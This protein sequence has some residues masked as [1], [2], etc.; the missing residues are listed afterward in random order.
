MVTI[1]VSNIF[2][3]GNVADADE[4]NDNFTDVFN[5]TIANARAI[6]AL[7]ITGNAYP[8]GGSE[9]CLPMDFTNS[10]YSDGV[11][12]AS[13]QPS[14]TTT[15]QWRGN[16]YRW[17]F[18]TY[19][20]NMEDASRDTNLWSVDAGTGTVTETGGYL[21]IVAVDAEPDQTKTLTLD[22]V[23]APDL[24]T[25]GICSIFFYGTIES[26]ISGATVAK[27]Q[28]IDE[29]AN[30]VDIKSYTSDVTNGWFEL[31]IDPGNDLADLYVNDSLAAEDV[32][33]SSLTGGDAWHLQFYV[34][35][36]ETGDTIKVRLNNLGWIEDSLATSTVES[37]TKTALENVSEAIVVHGYS[38]TTNG[39]THTPSVSSNGGTNYYEATF[40]ARTAITVASTTCQFKIVGTSTA[41]TRG[42]YVQ[43][44]AIMLWS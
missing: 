4:V 11:T 31:R 30:T 20:D 27:I 33:I 39:G 8:M 3:N 6:L 1:A 40:N 12:V 37:S 14:T 42:T 38:N 32:N 22:Q 13:E 18:T 26:S 41:N 28:L 19:I 15:A 21:E 35:N 9:Y 5:P 29:S 43:N 36:D 24:N 16:N 10:E 25:T 23:N 34:N 17:Y 44:G 7:C 2:V